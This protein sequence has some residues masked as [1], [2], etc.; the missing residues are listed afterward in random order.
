MVLISGAFENWITIVHPFSY[1]L[2][3]LANW[4]SFHLQK[5]GFIQQMTY[6]WPICHVYF[7]IEELMSA[8]LLQVDP[9]PFAA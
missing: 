1:Y 2:F 9:K 4:G 7:A 6:S 3:T 5:A 8:Q